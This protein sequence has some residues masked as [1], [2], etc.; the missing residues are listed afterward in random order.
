MKARRKNILPGELGTFSGKELDSETGFYYYGARYLDPRT[1]R[2][3][4]GDPAVWEYIPEAPINDEAKK[5]NGSLP[6]QGGV[7]NLVNLH[8][9]HYAGNNPVK[10][11]DPDGKYLINNVSSNVTNAREYVLRQGNYFGKVE[12]GAKYFN[13]RSNR[14]TSVFLPERHDPIRLPGGLNVSLKQAMEYKNDKNE[15]TNYDIKVDTVPLENGAFQIDITVTLSTMDTE[16]NKIEDIKTGTIGFVDIDEIR[17]LGGRTSQERANR[18][19]N[20]IISIVLEQRNP[21]DLVE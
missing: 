8:V 1:S 11:T 7:F 3:L 16:G 15:N 5:R 2:W 18:I 12:A 4:S 17:P 13:D 14:P 10:Y 20:E 21:V 6:G 9:Y 19:A